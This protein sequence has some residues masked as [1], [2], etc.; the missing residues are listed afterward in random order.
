VRAWVLIERAETPDG[1]ALELWQRGDQFSIRSAGRE[2]MGSSQ[3]G[4]EERL[5][6]LALAALDKAA[7][8]KAAHGTAARPRVLIGGLGFG[9]T[10][11]A[12]LAGLGSKARVVVDEI[13]PAVVAWNRGALGELAGQPL[14][15]P[16]VQLRTV[17]VIDDL[18]H[19]DE[20]FD[21]ILLDVDNGP[22][23]LSQARNAWLYGERGLAR[24][25]AALCP[26]GVLG[27][28]SAGP[29]ARFVQRLR[30]QRFRVDEHRVHAF[31]TRGKRHTIWI[32]KR[33]S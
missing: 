18:M 14:R 11:A 1:G 16:R 27:V 21:V 15:D 3:H 28:W 33:G 13:S 29:D 20:P 25:N 2:L 24:L 26:G 6:A 30:A 23:A 7:L 10:L 19:A 5:S 17:D 9:Y 8:D 22:S 4:S 32:A 31:G 12:A